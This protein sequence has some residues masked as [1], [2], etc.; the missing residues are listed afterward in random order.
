[1]YKSVFF[2]AFLALFCSPLGAQ[3]ADECTSADVIAVA[4]YATYVVAMDNTTAT[5]GLDPL[6]NPATCLVLGQFTDDIWFSFTPDG[7]GAVNVTTCDA[8]SWDTDLAMYDGSG[9]CAGLLEVACNG[10]ATTNPGP[11]QGFY[12]EFETAVAVTGGV[13]YYIRV[14]NWGGAGSGGTGNLTIDFFQTGAEV[15]DDGGDNDADGLIDCFDPDCVGVPPCGA[16]AGQC[17]DG[18]D[19]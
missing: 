7:D 11:C 9:G 5:T 8:T 12:S 13:T 6:P 3:G 19:N 16:E 18:V 14:G 15:C 1:M 2:I 4:G 10:D 17:N